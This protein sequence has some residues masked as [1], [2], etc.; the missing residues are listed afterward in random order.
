MRKNT[1]LYFIKKLKCYTKEILILTITLIMSTL[2]IFLQPLMIKQITDIGMVE[3][4]M[5]AIIVGTVGLSICAFSYLIIQVYQTKLFTK[6]HNSY[7]QELYNHAFLKLLHLKTSYFEAK[8]NTEIIQILQWDVSQVASITDNYVIMSFAY[9][10]RII[11]GL[12]G[13]CLISAKLLLPVVIA[14]PLKYLTVKYLSRKREQNM[15]ASI[16]ADQEL[17]GWFGDTIN[18]IKEIKLWNLYKKRNDSFLKKLQKTLNLNLSGT[19]IETWNTFGDSLVEWTVTVTLYFVGGYLI[20]KNQLSIGAVFA[21]LSYSSYVTRPIGC[22]LN[23]KMY[24]SRIQ[25]SSDRLYDFFQMSEE[26]TGRESINCADTPTIIFQN[27]K[28]QYSKERELLKNIS[29]QMSPGEKIGIIGEN[30]SGKSTI[31]ELLLRFYEPNDGA[32]LCNDKNIHDLN[33]SEYRDLFSVVSQKPFLFIG[34]IIENIDLTGNAE[35]NKLKDTLVQSKVAEYLE[36]FSEKEHTKVG[37][38]GATLSGGEKQKI[39]IARALLK[40]APIVI[41]D[42]A[43]TGFDTESRTYLHEMITSQMKEKTVLLITHH[44]EELDGFDKIYRLENGY[45]FPVK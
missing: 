34:T 14:I 6:L 5:N 38:D 22:L 41:L 37:N 31:I 19:M 43:T 45:L 11:S 15:N 1:L 24:F 27:V 8:N 10:F 17:S 4:N 26:R 20:C 23:I 3:K 42:E 18:A 12:A 33:L 44:Y 35:Q 32:I 13:L 40:N 28:F 36:H 7:Y 29:F 21:F 9:V 16:I 25:P 2:A 30:G 39:A